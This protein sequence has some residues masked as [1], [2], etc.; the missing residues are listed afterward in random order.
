MDSILLAMSFL[1]VGALII[2]LVLGANGESEDF[3]RGA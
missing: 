3:K 2:R 1:F